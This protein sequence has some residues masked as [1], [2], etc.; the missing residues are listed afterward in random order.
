VKTF[1][2]YGLVTGTKYL[3]EF[4]AETADEAVDMALQSDANDVSLCH[5]CSGGFDLDNKSCM[6]ATAEEI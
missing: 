2:V 5:Q 1:M 3:G 6:D 4:K